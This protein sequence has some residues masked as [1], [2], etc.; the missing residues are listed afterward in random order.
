MQNNAKISKKTLNY[1]TT[2]PPMKVG[3]RKKTTPLNRLT[4]AFEGLFLFFWN[5]YV[6]K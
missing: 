3:M 2:T 4:Q 5:V 1:Y 6:L